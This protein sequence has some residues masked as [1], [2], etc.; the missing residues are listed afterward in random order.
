MTT[1]R[2]QTSSASTS[3]SQVPDEQPEIAR[4]PSPSTG[5]SGIDSPVVSDS[6]RQ[7]SSPEGSASMLSPE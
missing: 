3:T 4:S 6:V 1:T 5:D 7:P 2:H